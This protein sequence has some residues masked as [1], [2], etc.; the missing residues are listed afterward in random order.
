MNVTRK[1]LHTAAIAARRS[2]DRHRQ[3]IGFSL[4]ADI[5]R[6]HTPVIT[7]FERRH[8]LAAWADDLEAESLYRELG[9]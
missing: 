7:G 6:G 9:L 8:A 5:L 2:A 3:A 1:N 4:S